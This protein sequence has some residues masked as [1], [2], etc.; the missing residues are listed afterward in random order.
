M[1]CERD[2]FDDSALSSYEQRWKRDFGR[3]LLL[4]FRLFQL[5]RSL[6]AEEVDQLLMV[7]KDPSLLETIRTYGDMDRP[8]KMLFQLARKPAFY[9][10]LRILMRKGLRQILH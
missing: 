5:R 4:G 1:C 3:E 10:L 6:S 8:Q 7:L 9:P 2:R